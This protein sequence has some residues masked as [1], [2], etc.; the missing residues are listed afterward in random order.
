LK[1][2]GL[3]FLMLATRRMAEKRKVDASSGCRR[4]AMLPSSS[5]SGCLERHNRA[6]CPPWRQPAGHC[7]AEAVARARWA[8]CVTHSKLQPLPNTG[9]SCYFLVLYLNIV[10]QFR[11][12]A[13][14][15][16]RFLENK[17]C[18]CNL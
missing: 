6:R 5:S 9:H 1:V 13:A 16:V 18:P 10:L 15:H 7:N 12:A 8:E 2:A 3:Q 14:L 11:K 4:L 17:G